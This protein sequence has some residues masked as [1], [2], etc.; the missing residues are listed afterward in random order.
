MA[1]ETG[2]R[3]QP[4]NSNRV[5]SLG[6]GESRRNEEFFRADGM[7]GIETAEIND[8]DLTG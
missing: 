3:I 6:V 2:F 4:R 8:K 7:A 5:C 1:R